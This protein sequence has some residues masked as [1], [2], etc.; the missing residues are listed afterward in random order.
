M[1]GWK[2]YID[3]QLEL[4]IVMTVLGI[5]NIEPHPIIVEIFKLL[6][7]SFLSELPKE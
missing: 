7:N 3:H 2:T 5:N 6:D 4:N 1:L